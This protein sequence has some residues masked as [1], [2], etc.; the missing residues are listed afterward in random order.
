MKHI[1]SDI[2]DAD[3]SED[4]EKLDFMAE[5]LQKVINKTKLEHSK[6]RWDYWIIIEL[7]NYELLMYELQKARK[8]VNLIINND[9]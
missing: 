1:L 2:L 3:I 6:V 9:E 4:I 8:R 5:E 7:K